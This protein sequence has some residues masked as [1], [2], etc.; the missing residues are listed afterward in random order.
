ML[1]WNPFLR[2]VQDDSKVASSAS[3]ATPS[4][5]RRYHTLGP[6]A[7]AGVRPLSVE[8]ALVRL[9]ELNEHLDSATQRK[10]P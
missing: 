8:T 4:Q 1:D 7:L 10:K 3:R 9:M 5:Q 6:H 2:P